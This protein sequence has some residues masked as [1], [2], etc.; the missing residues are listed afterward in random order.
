V[1]I[2]SGETVESDFFRG[3]DYWKEALKGVAVTTM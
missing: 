2:K 3:L 1:A